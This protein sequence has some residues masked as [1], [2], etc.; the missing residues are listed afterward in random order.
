MIGYRRV[1]PGYF[2]ALGVPILRGRGFSEE[3]RSPAEKPVILSEPSR[4]G[5]F[6]MEKIRWVILPVR[7]T[8]HLAHHRRIAVT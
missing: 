2:P 4:K 3:D 6:Y 5:F 8:E 1:S 7:L